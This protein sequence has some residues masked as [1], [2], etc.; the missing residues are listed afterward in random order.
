MLDQAAGFPGWSSAGFS[1]TA[2]YAWSQMCGYCMLS[3]ARQL[4][5]AER[6]PGD[7]LVL[8]PQLK[9]RAPDRRGDQG[10]AAERLGHGIGSN[11]SGC[12]LC[13]GSGLRDLTAG[14]QAWRPSAQAGR[15]PG[16]QIQPRARARW[17]AS[18]RL[19]APS[20]AA[21]EER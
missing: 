7:H 11:V 13:G 17:A 18:W 4:G 6:R 9:R 1:W 14:P 10:A 5:G 12:V 20:L 15:R 2:P 19:A 16:G 21:A 8:G 3:T